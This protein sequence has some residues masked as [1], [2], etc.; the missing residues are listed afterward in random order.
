M[1]FV[2]RVVVMMQLSAVLHCSRVAALHL[3]KSVRSFQLSQRSFL[4]SS[5]INGRHFGQN[6]RQT[7][8]F[9]STTAGVSVDKIVSAIALKGDEIRN[10]KANKAGKDAISPVVAELLQLKKEFQ[11]L[12]GNPFDPPKEGAAV[13]ATAAATVSAPKEK[14]AK[15]EDSQSN[16]A[17]GTE[18]TVITP[19]GTDYSAW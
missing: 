10:L 8:L 14:S 19:R 11:E 6:G 3:P 17:K 15:K 5:Q 13:V 16:Q 4:S 12:T 2:T 7:S 9:C 18:S 1:L